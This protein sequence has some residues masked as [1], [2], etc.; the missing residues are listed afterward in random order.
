MSSLKELAQQTLRIV[1]AG[2]Y[3]SPA[4]R[5]VRIASEVA[6][7]AA[8]TILVRPG[9]SAS[10]VFE[11]YEGNG[12]VEVTEETTAQAA[13]RLVQRPGRRRGRLPDQLRP[14]QSA[15]RTPRPRPFPSEHRAALHPFREA[16]ARRADVS[17]SSGGVSERRQ[18][19]SGVLHKERSLLARRAH[20]A[21]TSQK[22]ATGFS[23]DSLAL[24]SWAEEARD[25]RATAPG[26]VPDK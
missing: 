13:R 1:E 4:G 22:R 9:E 14:A 21:S 7:A 16:G 11:R 3:V 15:L 25:R 23:R 2:E 8:G 12:R 24:R 10:Y 6:A 19:E 5:T 20:V 17:R 26:L 18:T